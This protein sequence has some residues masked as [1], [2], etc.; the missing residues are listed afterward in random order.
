MLIRLL[1]PFTLLLSKTPLLATRCGLFRA[2]FCGWLLDLERQIVLRALVER[3]TDALCYTAKWINEL[4][5]CLENRN[6]SR[7]GT[8]KAAK[9]G[10]RS[11][12]QP[13]LG[14]KDVRSRRL[15]L[16]SKQ[17]RKVCS[18]KLSK[19]VPVL[20]SSRGVWCTYC[21]ARRGRRVRGRDRYLP[22]PRSG[23]ATPP[24]N[25]PPGRNDSL[26]LRRGKG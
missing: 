15:Q 20:C 1:A 10:R 2:T 25:L 19:V 23:V 26:I 21:A 4:R 18:Q 5:N 24:T 17:F 8:T 14:A 13:T 9:M 11:P 7:I 3:L 22:P 6:G 12:D 16:F